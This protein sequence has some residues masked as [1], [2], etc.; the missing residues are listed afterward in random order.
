MARNS[1]RGLLRLPS[2]IWKI[3]CVGTDIQAL[4][5]IMSLLITNYKQQLANDKS[6]YLAI[7]FID[8]LNNNVSCPFNQ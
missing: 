6:V 7:A 8:V 2:G 3:S 4:F 1:S 5:Y